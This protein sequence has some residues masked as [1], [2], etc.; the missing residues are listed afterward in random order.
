MVKEMRVIGITIDPVTQT[1]IV[2]LRDKENM[3]T[4]PIWIGILEANAIAVGLENVKLPRPMTHDLF[5]SLLDQ[6][7]LRLLRVEVTDIKESTYYAVLHIDREGKP[8]VIDCRPSDAI[9]IAIRMEI[10]IM[11][12]DAVIEKALRTDAAAAP[13]GEKDKWTE[14]LER[15]NPE[16]FSKYKM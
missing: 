12:R 2:I 15:M 4:L 9:A 8:L 14:L 3:N 7:G 16:D 11:V 13:G 5:K 1:P 10:P 6:T